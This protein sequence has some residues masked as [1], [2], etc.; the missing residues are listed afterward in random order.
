MPVTVHRRGHAHR[1]RR[2]ARGVCTHGHGALAPGQAFDARDFQAA[3]SAGPMQV[4]VDGIGL[5]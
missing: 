3:L 2:A 5:G 4:A 1:D